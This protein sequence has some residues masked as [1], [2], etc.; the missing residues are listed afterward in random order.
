MHRDDRG[1]QEM[2]IR[3]SYYTLLQYDRDLQIARQSYEL[4][5]QSAALI[6]S[7]FRYGM[8]NGVALQR[9]V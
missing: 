8:S 5:R 3:D 7:M 6:D 2:C 4:R 1:R 9:C